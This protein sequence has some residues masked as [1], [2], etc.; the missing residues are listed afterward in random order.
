MYTLALQALTLF[1]NW[2]NIRKHRFTAIR[3]E[4]EANQPDFAL[5]GIIA[6]SEL[7]YP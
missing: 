7:L 5:Y 2:W 6:E 4:V 1:S 3:T